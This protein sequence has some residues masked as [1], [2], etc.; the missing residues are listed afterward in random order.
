MGVSVPSLWLLANWKNSLLPPW[1][2]F[3]LCNASSI[4]HKISKTSAIIDPWGTLFIACSLPFK[5]LFTSLFLVSEHIL[6]SWQKAHTHPNPMVMQCFE[7][8][9][10]WKFVKGFLVFLSLFFFFC[11]IKLF[12]QTPLAR[13]LFAISESTN[14]LVELDCRHCV[15]SV[16]RGGSLHSV[17][18]L[19]RCVLLAQSASLGHGREYPGSP[20]SKSPHLSSSFKLS[21]TSTHHLG[22]TQ[23]SGNNYDQKEGG[24]KKSWPDN[25]ELGILLT[26]LCA[27]NSGWTFS[28]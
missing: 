26:L 27:Q 15:V 22:S 25:W 1:W 8:L 23:A 9:S 5:V 20:S 14:K 24:Y 17:Y 6:Y 19:L 18:L 10:M 16:I 21:L 13:C 11:L 2:D 7:Q 3:L 12:P 28:L 4:F